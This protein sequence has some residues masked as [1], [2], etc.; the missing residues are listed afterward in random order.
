MK[1]LRL[2]AALLVLG[3]GAAPIAAQAQIAYA[4]T[5][6]TCGT[7]NN[8]PVVGNTY[9]VTMD[10]T[11][12]L[13]NSSTGVVTSTTKPTGGTTTDSSSTVTAGGTFQSAIA[14]SATRLGCLVENPV[15]ATETLFVF[16]GANGSATTANSVSLAPGAAFSCA[17][18]TGAVLTDNISVTATTTGHAF[19]A[20]AQ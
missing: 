6:T 15:S 16:P 20:K 2:L 3:W 9:P 17:T 12:K 14:A 1:A 10:T 18:G 4:Q 19:I 13:C 5:V 7:P 8:T 11:G